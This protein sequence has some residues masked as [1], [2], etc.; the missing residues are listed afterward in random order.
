MR[1]MEALV[2]ASNLGRRFGRR[3]AVARV[4]LTI[5]ADERLLVIGPNG[6]GKTTL[7]RVLSTLLPPQQGQ[8][9]RG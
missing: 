1:S 3:W 6:C 5:H 2:Q 9:T 4:D 8:P 7:L